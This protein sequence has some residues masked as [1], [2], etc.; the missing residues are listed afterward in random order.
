MLVGI[1]ERNSLAAESIQKGVSLR[2]KM[3]VGVGS[4][5]AEYREIVFFTNAKNPNV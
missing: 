3:D 4:P 2:L 1:S 5:Y